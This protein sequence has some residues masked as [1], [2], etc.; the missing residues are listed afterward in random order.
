[1]K[2]LI[3]IG[4][5]GHG[6]E[7]DEYIRYDN[8][9]SSTVKYN[10]VGFLDDSASS[11]NG[12]SLS[13]PLL[14]SIADHEVRQD[15]EY[16][17]GIA[18]L[19]YRKKFTELFL[20][21]GARFHTYIHP[22]SFISESAKIGTGSVISYHCNIGPNAVLGNFNMVNARASVAHDSI[23]GSYNFI[24][25]NVCLSGFTKVGDENLFGIN[26]ATIPGIHIGSRNKIAAGMTLD[27]NVDDDSTVFYRMKERI[28]TVPKK[29]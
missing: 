12:Y 2:N 3:I 19:E 17:M 16:I 27:K 4:S 6:A 8:R 20:K 25:P 18:N 9:R 29:S 1:M 23:V 22:E 14:G 26:S 10:L 11:Y 21:K 5:G 15:C 13:A 24:G 28:M 7:L